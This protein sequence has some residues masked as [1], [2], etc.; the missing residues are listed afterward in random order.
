MGWKDFGLRAVGL[1]LV[2]FVLIFVFATIWLT[3]NIVPTAEYD[4][5]VWISAFYF[6]SFASL[7]LSILYSAIW[8]WKGSNY[9]P[10]KILGSAIK[11]WYYA[12]A[13]L[14]ILSGIATQL[15]ILP[16]A[17]AGYLPANI[18]VVV[19]S[20]FS[21]YTLSIMAAA[22]PVKYIPPLAMNFHK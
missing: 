2:S 6:T 22:T 17:I 13:L 3:D 18:I 15:F 11:F 7:S 9:Y 10:Q 4:V 19:I 20:L 21:Y 5:D 1:V 8:F 14:T 12:L 16:P